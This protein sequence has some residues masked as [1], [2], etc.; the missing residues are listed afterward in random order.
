VPA[1]TPLPRGPSIITLYGAEDLLS[2]PGCPVCR[3][4]G[5]AADRY[6]HWFALEGHAQAEMIT[7]LCRSL[8]MCA[9]HTRLL[10]GQPGAATRLTAVYRYVLAAARDRL[11]GDASSPDPC[12][13]CKHADSAVGRA[14][15]TLID[16]LTSD[17]ILSRCTDL[18]GVCIPHLAAAA[19]SGARRGADSL[20][21][22]MQRTLASGRIGWLAGTDHDAEARAGLRARLPS[23][24]TA[25]ARVCAACV[26][27]AQA[28][29]ESLAS[30]LAG[31]ADAWEKADA[32]LLL[33][34]THLADAAIALSCAGRER[35]LLTWQAACAGAGI[36][37][38]GAVL[39][40]LHS[41]ARRARGWLEACVVCHSG[42]GA[43]RRRLADIAG[44]PPPDST[45][46]L[47]HHLVLG[48]VDKR[49]ASL[50][51]PDLAGFAAWLIAELATAFERTTW[52]QHRSGPVRTSDAWLQAAAFLDGG[53]FGGHPPPVS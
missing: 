52:V 35:P 29:R 19:R 13:A 22:A 6:L 1:A 24:L 10:I 14:L 12:P 20:A 18:G 8:G 37:S 11:S 49:A 28:E 27:A 26:A 30:V 32:G 38:T 25:A 46:C 39:Q 31:Q 53:V 44:A 51:A 48:K 47:R 17:E 23:G 5:E 4:A 21:A 36:R 40:R 42:Q 41:R 50:V 9:R 45:L 2:G 15:D 7:S 3:Y 16:G 43:V 34:G 33:C